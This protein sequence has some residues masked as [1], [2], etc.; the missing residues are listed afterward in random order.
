MSSAVYIDLW[1]GFGRQ[2]KQPITA[3]YDGA[4]SGHI[5]ILNRALFKITFALKQFKKH[6]LLLTNG[7]RIKVCNTETLDLSPSV[8]PI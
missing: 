5:N 8:K 1:G 7:D 4:S 3:S 2:L 6:N